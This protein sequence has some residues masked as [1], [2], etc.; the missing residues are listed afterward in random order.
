M[1]KIIFGLLLASLVACKIKSPEDKLAEKILKSPTIIEM[2][3]NILKLAEINKKIR[4][5][6]AVINKYKKLDSLQRKDSIMKL[7][8]HNDD[9][10]SAMM[11]EMETLKKLNKEFPELNKLSGESRKIVFQKVFKSDKFKD[12]LKPFSTIGDK[13][14]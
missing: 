8:L 12:A 14:N 6:T 7:Y 2:E 3:S 1:H 13:I 9:Y 5:D 11:K 10:M 4:Q